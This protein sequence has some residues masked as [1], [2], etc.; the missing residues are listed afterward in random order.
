M[1]Q[2][3]VMEKTL[4]NNNSSS[5]YN[6]KLGKDGEDIAK[7]LLLEKGFTFIDSNF[8]CNLGEIDLIFSHRITIIFVE[9][10]T[11]TSNHLGNPEEA[12]TKGKLSH[13][14][15]AAQFF[16]LKNPQYK[17]FQP[18]I[19]VVAIDLATKDVRHYEAVY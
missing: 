13:L 10:K 4:Q 2:T 16:L 9:V 7:K 3:I 8:S 18:R 1:V 17:N 11:R 6:Q 14:R 15:K 19:D 5:N 12:I